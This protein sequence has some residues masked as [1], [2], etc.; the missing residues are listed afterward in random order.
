MY[1]AISGWDTSRVDD[2]ENLFDCTPELSWEEKLEETFLQRLKAKAREVI[3]TCE[4]NKRT[5]EYVA[6]YGTGPRRSAAG[7][8]W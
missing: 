7:P 2:M 4:Y 3:G 1:G 8:R 5:D 6:K